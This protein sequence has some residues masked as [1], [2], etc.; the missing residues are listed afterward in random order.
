MEFSFGEKGC[1]GEASILNQ[2]DRYFV[3]R[4]S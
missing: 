3:M 1:I 4:L 2:Q